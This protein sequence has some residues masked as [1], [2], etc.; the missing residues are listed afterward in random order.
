M[1]RR[2]RYVLAED[3]LTV[4]INPFGYFVENI[5]G[6]SIVLVREDDRQRRNVVLLPFN[7]ER[8]PRDIIDQILFQAGFPTEDFWAALDEYLAS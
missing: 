1:P 2:R 6:S 5:G 8:I 4:L 3:A 7:T